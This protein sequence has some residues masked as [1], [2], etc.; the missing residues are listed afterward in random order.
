MQ[1]SQQLKDIGTGQAGVEHGCLEAVG[2]RQFER[3]G[4]VS[5]MVNLHAGAFERGAHQR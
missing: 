3:R 2:L 4:A 5:G 1:S